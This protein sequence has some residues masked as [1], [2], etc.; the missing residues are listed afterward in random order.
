MIRRTESPKISGKTKDEV[1]NLIKQDNRFGKIVCRCEMISEMEIINAINSPL[2]P[3]SIDAI[4]RRTRAGMGRCQGGF[5]F[6]KVM[7]LISKCHNI[8]IDDITK[9][10]SGSRLIVGDIK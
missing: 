10:N 5:C 1:N 7:E 8:P 2:K 9:E 6:S 4:K 3:M